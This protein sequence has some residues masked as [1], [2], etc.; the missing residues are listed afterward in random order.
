MK[1]PEPKKGLQLVRHGEGYRVKDGPGPVSASFEDL[2]PLLRGRTGFK[3]I[4]RLPFK[5]MESPDH[6]LLMGRHV[7]LEIDK[8]GKSA[9]LLTPSG[10]AHRVDVKGWMLLVDEQGRPKIVLA[11][12]DKGPVELKGL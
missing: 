7:F 2:G 9:E 4:G 10:R 3:G 12:T 6:P 11:K 1:R 8:S 5:D